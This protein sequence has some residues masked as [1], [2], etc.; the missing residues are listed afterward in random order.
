[1]HEHVF[2][3]DALF[4]KFR[5]FWGIGWFVIVKGWHA[6]EFAILLLLCVAALTRLTGRYTALTIAL[7]ILLCF[8]FAVSDEWHQ[9][10]IPDRFGTATD[11]LIDSLGFMVAGLVLL[12][13]LR[14]PVRK[15]PAPGDAADQP[16]LST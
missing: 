9:T 13:K 7:A 8:G 11:V 6:T 3:E 15:A 10:F 1:M 16:D 4:S 5:V 12:R 2:L 14:I